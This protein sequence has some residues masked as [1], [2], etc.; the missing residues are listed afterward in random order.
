MK[1]TLYRIY[2]LLT[3]C[4]F[5]HLSVCAASELTYDIVGTGIAP[6]SEN[7]CVLR[8]RYGFLWVG[9][10]PGLS[11]YDGNCV[12]VYGSN[13]AALR[14]MSNVSVS[15]FYEN[16][17]DI[18]I[19]GNT[20]LFVFD[21]SAN[22]ISNFP[23]KT[24]YGVRIAAVVEKIIDVGQGLT[25][26]C[27]QGQGFFI[28]NNSD[29]TLVQN[30]RHGSFY[31][32]IALGADGRVYI[33]ELNGQI[34]TYLPDGKFVGT[35]RLP[36][37]ETDKNQI[38]MVSSGRDIWIASD[39]YVY[40]LD[41]ETGIIRRINI[42]GMSGTITSLL[43]RPNGT[44]LI[45][46]PMGLWS[47]NTIGNSLSKID[48]PVLQP[49]T[50]RDYRVLSTMADTDGDIF[51]IHPTGPIDVMITHSPAF[52]FVPVANDA[53][54]FVH[55][56]IPSLDG[57]GLWVGSNHGLDYY[58][59]AS[60]AVISNKIAGVGHRDITSL[61]P[62]GHK[63]WIGTR[64]SGLLLYDSEKKTT[65]NFVYNEN[66]P[67]SVISNEINDVY[68]TERGEIFVLTNWGMC[69]Y[70]ADAGNFP[71][72][73]EIGQ[74]IH[75]SA[76]QE[77]GRG[78]VWVAT[79]NN[80]MYYRSPDASR[81]EGV[82]ATSNIGLVPV[83]AMCRDHNGRVWAATHKN[84][85]FVYDDAAADFVPVEVPALNNTTVSFMTEDSRNRIWI[86]TNNSLVRIDNDGTSYSFNIGQRGTHTPVTT[87]VR[88]LAN[89]ILAMGCRGGF[90]LFDPSAMQS[91]K[92]RT[93]VYPCTLSL[94]Y[95]RDDSDEL[96]RYGLDVLLYTR[97]AVEL[98]YD[99]N[100]FTIH[101][102]AARPFVGSD[103]RYDYMLSGVDNAWN[104]CTAMP[105]VTYN[106]LPP[107]EYEF[108]LRP[109]GF[110]NAEATKLSVSILPPWYLS[111]IA[112]LVY[113]VLILVAI[114][115]IYMLSRKLVRRNLH[116]RMQELRIQKERETFEAKT[117]YFVDLVHEIRTPLMLISLPLE[118][119]AEQA[120]AE[121]GAE[122]APARNRNG[123]YI[124]SMQQNIDYLL[125][126]T[127]QLLDFRRAENDS[128]IRL[129]L[130]HCNFGNMLVHLCHRFDEPMKISG[131]TIEL[132]LPEQDVWATIDIDKTER[133]L[134]NM[135]GN[136]MKY[137]RAEVKVTLKN[138]S[139]NTLSVA[140]A[141]DG[142]G[143]P[144][145]ERKHIFNTYYQIGN[146]KVAAT[147]GTG[148]GLAYA[149]LIANAHGGS[150]TV[151]DNPLGCGAVFTI[152]LPKGDE[153]TVVNH[154][155]MTDF[156]Y[157]PETVAPLN[158]DVTVL[159]VEDNE[160]LRD[161]VTDTLGRHYS[162]ITAPNGEVALELLSG[163]K[164]DL[165]V[166][167]VM[168]ETIDGLELC[169]RVKGD[170]NYSHIPF[171]ILTAVTTR[172]THEE[173]LRC[174]ADVYL[175]KPFPIKQLVLQIENLLKTR[176][177]LHRK[178]SDDSTQSVL[179]QAKSGLNRLDA[180]FLE[181]MNAIIAESISN[182]EFSI[183][184]L[185]QKLNMSRSSFY[186]KITSVTGMPPNDYLKNF[187]LNYAVQ[188]LLDNCRVTEVAERV[189]F[190]S[191][192][193]FAK[194][195]RDKF[196]V[197][198]SEYVASLNSKTEPEVG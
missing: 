91:N 20:G 1:Q 150:I 133:L 125:G 94:P 36:D 75:A 49:F 194:C 186:R 97:K 68:R 44:L 177:Q 81:F 71:Q 109:H 89:G 130:T 54:E 113:L 27:T 46:T 115:G 18:W 121:G 191:S 64:N 116:K 158:Q 114:C 171:I 51:I 72:L 160:D 65:T 66:I 8:D 175:E 110:R 24:K 11:C 117:R 47:Y 16:G 195:F 23:H 123:K 153:K 67:Y 174:G 118:R 76:M 173:G 101:L 135:L 185:A 131:K 124:K 28:F 25:W 190:T 111:R 105:E 90:L 26:I 198:P 139:D 134:M 140:V 196:G 120:A 180:E 182:E 29:S 96:S 189:G 164:I 143:V 176:R 183:D 170:I 127:N 9:S 172:E 45:C 165:I 166:S 21:R 56:I 30:S 155:E 32:D 179:P 184:L 41:I 12:P 13:S 50:G 14:Q 85:I 84:G 88:H 159:L 57:K 142:P 19:G 98:P 103:V 3:A 77:D 55:A 148:L 149:K 33:A 53:V 6:D 147:L 42:Y 70:D 132:E 39:E 107:G 82:A 162:V 22:T 146:D 7:R 167:D 138:V 35:S 144:E 79:A 156:T 92:N 73:T 95:L 4:L 154:A 59:M 69:R 83:I 99:M 87:S 161:M 74:Q 37:Y 86:G 108:L 169:R 38:H 112:M 62:D 15:A 63:L 163:N 136:A 10:N 17:D 60:G 193:Y 187:R 80:G 128:E 151:G 192:S 197:L 102:S 152:T 31:S 100:T 58:D 145:E 40:K 178:M 106:N 61:T 43:S 122:E 78:G 119:I 34:Q 168:M 129:N 2:L 5:I 157:S 48:F 52:R 126:I 188:L 181:K 137:A 141:D 93:R 104:I